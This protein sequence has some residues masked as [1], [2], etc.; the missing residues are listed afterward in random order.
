MTACEQKAWVSFKDVVKNFLGNYRDKNYKVYVE[1]V[2]NHYRALGCNMSL[3]VHF[4]HSHLDFFPENLGDVSEEQGERFHQDI[5]DMEHR[6]Q[7]Y[8]NVKMMA[9]YCWTLKRDCVTNNK[10]RKARKRAFLPKLL[11]FMFHL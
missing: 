10:G 5:K 3:K 8:W 4:L 1:T 2:L 7:G 9:D 6:Y 11:F